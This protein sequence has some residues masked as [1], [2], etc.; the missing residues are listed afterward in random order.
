MYPEVRNRQK[1]PFPPQT[2]PLERVTYRI[3]CV[4]TTGEDRDR[5]DQRDSEQVDPCLYEKGTWCEKFTELRSVTPVPSSPYRPVPSMLIT[6]SFPFTLGTPLI[7]F[8][9]PGAVT[10]NHTG[11]L[12]TGRGQVTSTSVPISRFDL[13]QVPFRGNL[14][15]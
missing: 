8:L 15:S 10:R 3:K 12:T 6:T 14:S 5:D 1:G 11:T 13:Y 7:K 9:Y 4:F 2:V